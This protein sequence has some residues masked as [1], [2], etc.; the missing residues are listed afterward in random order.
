MAEEVGIPKRQTQYEDNAIAEAMGRID[1]LNEDTHSPEQP[2]RASSHNYN[3]PNETIRQLEDECDRANPP[4]THDSGRVFRCWRESS[5][6]SE[7]KDFIHSQSANP[8]A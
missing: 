4:E 2:E 7:I 6:S 8:M 3:P 1:P 5:Q